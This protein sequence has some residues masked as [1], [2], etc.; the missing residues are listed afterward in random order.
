MTNSRPDHKGLLTI[1]VPLIR[2]KI[3]ALFLMGVPEP[4]GVPVDQP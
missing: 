2:P 4:W 3:Q 1:V